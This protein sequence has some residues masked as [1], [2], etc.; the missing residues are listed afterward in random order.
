MQKN[1]QTSSSS[2]APHLKG[3]GVRARL[4]SFL[5]LSNCVLSF[6]LYL[7]FNLN[8]PSSPPPPSF[9]CSML[10]ECNVPLPMPCPFSLCVLLSKTRSPFFNLFPLIKLH[11]TDNTSQW[12][13]RAMQCNPS[14][15]SPCVCVSITECIALPL[16]SPSSL[17]NC[18]M[19]ARAASQKVYTVWTEANH[20]PVRIGV[21]H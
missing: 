4:F 5:C 6:F 7:S 8:Y 14:L 10:H 17:V 11:P 19:H 3:V 20:L 15:S 13:Q 18:N 12:R 16:S 2:L 21:R 1:K 9:C